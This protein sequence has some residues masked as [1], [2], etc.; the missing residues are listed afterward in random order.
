MFYRIVMSLNFD[1]RDE[2][3]DIMD[4]ALDHLAESIV[5]HAGEDNEEGGFIDLEQ[6]F[7]DEDPTLPCKFIRREVTTIT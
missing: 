3:E 4:K 7:H 6:C 2:A 1:N 5:I